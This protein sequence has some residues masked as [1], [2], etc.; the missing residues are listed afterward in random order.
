MC[1][2]QKERI[3]DILKSLKLLTLTPEI[4]KSTKIGL[5]VNTIKKK[6]DGE[7]GRF[8]KELVQIWR[9]IYNNS[10]PQVAPA[11]AQRGDS[12]GSV[13][14]SAVG[15]SAEVPPASPSQS[16][17]PDEIGE[18]SSSAGSPRPTSAS[19]GF[20]KLELDSMPEGRRNVVLLISL[21]F[22]R[23]LTSSQIIKL[24]LAAFE[25]DEADGYPREVLVSIARGIELTINNR[26]SFTRDRENYQTRARKLIFNL[27]KNKVLFSSR[28][29]SSPALTTF[30][31]SFLSFF[32]R[33][34]DI[35]MNILDGLLSLADLITLPS[36][37]LATKE[38]C[39]Q[40]NAA[41]DEASESRRS[42]WIAANREKVMLDN[43]LDPTKGTEFKCHKCRSSKCTFYAL[44]TRSSDEPMTLFVT[45]LNCGNNWKTC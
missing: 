34:Q 13:R 21:F 28:F 5:S 14:K 10:Q 30:S 33:Q 4:I 44:Q 3:L 18:Q 36:T 22:S 6:Y 37:A 16:R 20:G 19:E 17:T 23:Q 45:C 24:L 7:V 25:P 9:S 43:G 39:D 11:G 26:Y 38:L 8:A 31:L 27:K 35:R 40:R 32:S 1:S 15:G 2:Q 29:M 42:D 41:R 12:T